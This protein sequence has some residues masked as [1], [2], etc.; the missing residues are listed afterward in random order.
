METLLYGLY[1][2]TSSAGGCA[3]LRFGDLEHTGKPVTLALGVTAAEAADVIE[4]DIVFGGW[5]QGQ[6]G[7]APRTLDYEHVAGGAVEFFNAVD[8]VALWTLP[9]CLA[10]AAPLVWRLSWRIVRRG[11]L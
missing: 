8:G 2:T 4:A 1:A 5:R 9:P 6:P 7:R 11:W 10:W 3:V